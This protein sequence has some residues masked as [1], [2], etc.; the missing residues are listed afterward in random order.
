MQYLSNSDILIC[1]WYFV[2]YHA[3]CLVIM[4]TYFSKSNLVIFLFLN[5]FIKSSIWV[6][7]FKYER[8]VI[9]FISCVHHAHINVCTCLNF[10]R[11]IYKT[12]HDKNMYQ[13]LESFS[14]IFRLVIHKSFFF[15]VIMS[16]IRNFN[17]RS[18]TSFTAFKELL[19]FHRT[20]F[21]IYCNYWL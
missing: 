16:N 19:I 21:T 15:H 11:K 4:T 9:F 14:T 1:N 5:L 3:L 20:H 7:L 18:P 8:L 13:N 6:F 2:F 10:F 12:F 17:K